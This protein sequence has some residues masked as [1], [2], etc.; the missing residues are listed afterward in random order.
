MRWYAAHVIIGLAQDGR[1]AD[2]PI[3]CWENVIILNAK[4]ECEAKEM[5]IAFGE[6]EAA[7]DDQLRID[8][9]MAKRVFAGVRKI[10]SISNIDGS[11]DEA[12]PSHGS[13]ITYSQ[14]IVSSI[15]DLMQLGSGDEVNIVYTDR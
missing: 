4:D 6:E 15:G 3:L 5:A 10:V 2:D 9:I 11:Q 14:Y 7:I 12:P 13:E 1:N 8:N